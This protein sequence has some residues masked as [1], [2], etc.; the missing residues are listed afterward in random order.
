MSCLHPINIVNPSSH[1]AFD[2]PTHLRVPCGSC[3]ECRRTM[4]DEWFFR[5]VIEYMY[6]KKRGGATYFVTLTYNNQCL[7]FLELCDKTGKVLQ[8]VKCF[9]YRHIHNFIKYFRMLLKKNGYEWKYMKYLV[10]C[11]YGSKFGRPHYHILL[12]FP[13]RL[14]ISLLI[15]LLRQAWKHGYI[16]RSKLGFEVI[17]VKGIRYVMKYICKDMDF[18]RQSNF[19]NSDEL[20]VD[21]VSYKDALPRHWQSVHYGES[22]IDD[23]VMKQSFPAAFLAQNTFSLPIGQGLRCLYAIPRYYHKKMETRV[24][25]DWSKW[26]G[27]VYQEKTDLGKDVS[28][29]RFAKSIIF[30]MAFLKS[31]KRELLEMVF[32][33]SMTLENCG[34]TLHDSFLKTDESSYVEVENYS[35]YTSFREYVIDTILGGLERLN[36]Y[37]LSVYR[38]F[39]RDYPLRVGLDPMLYF[40]D[41]GSL[42]AR[43]IDAPNLPPEV[44]D[45]NCVFDTDGD[46]TKVSSP[47]YLLDKNDILKMHTFRNDFR[48]RY[49]ERIAVALDLFTHYSA[50]NKHAVRELRDIRLRYQKAM[51][52]DDYTCFTSL[53]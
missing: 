37:H 43:F 7:P 50:I 4:Q 15:R 5:G 19:F 26:L 31:L 33:D 42:I 10:C 21:S 11:E 2:M 51:F 8:K 34:Y 35:D 40:H 38:L 46:I 12:H 22:F 36:L 23:V 48:M 27:K 14:P 6:Y 49:F 29:I 28:S 1:F 17:N 45:T 24:N 47:L 20:D 18:Y 3:P 44:F 32:P 41:V 16:S 30:D 52:A 53:N 25:K 13:Y 39:L 9:S